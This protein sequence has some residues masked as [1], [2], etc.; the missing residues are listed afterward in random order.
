MEIAN[1]QKPKKCNIT[2]RSVLKQ[3]ELHK[4][5]ISCEGKICISRV[6]RFSKELTMIRNRE[7]VG[8]QRVIS[9]LRASCF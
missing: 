3:I 6:N 4:L 7:L 5:V 2:S 1:E 8:N 9:V